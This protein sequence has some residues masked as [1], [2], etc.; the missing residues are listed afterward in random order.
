MSA[1]PAEIETARRIRRRILVRGAVQGVGFRPFV[2][3]RAQALGLSGWV[4]NTAEGVALEIEGGR[5]RV[6]ALLRAL[7]RAPPPNALVTAIAIEALAPCG[8]RGFAIRRSEVA[9]DASAQILPDIAPCAACL[10]ELFDAANRRYRYPFISCSQCGPRYTIIEDGPYDR[11]RTVM[12]Q[13]P[14]CPACQAEYGDP[15]DRRFHAETSACAVCGPRLSLLDGDGAVVARDDT[16]L[17]TAAAALRAGSIVALKG[18]GGFHL[19]A[20]AL[21]DAAVAE[22]RRRKRRPEK[23]FAVMFPSL[24]ALRAGCRLS[25]G[26]AALLTAPARP[27]VLLRRDGAAVAPGVA[28]GNPWLGAMLPSSPLHHL[29]LAALPFPVVATSGN[30]SGEPI[31]IDNAEALARLGGVA[32]RFLV[33]DRPILRP[34]DDSVVRLVARRGLVLRRARGYAPTTLPIRGVRAGVLAVGGHLKTAVA[35]TRENSVILGPHV[36]DLDT[37]AAREAHGRAVGDIARL[38]GVAINRLARDRH[39]DYASARAA[40]ALGLPA[41]AVPHHLAHLVACMAENGIT[42]PVLGVVWDGSGFGEDGTIWGGEFLAVTATG[43]RRI[44]HLRRFRLPGGE[45]AAREPRRA[46]LGMLY[47]AYGG[48]AFAMTDLPPVAAFTARERGVLGTMLVRAVNAPLCSSM[49]RLFDG[50]SALCGLRQRAS[51]EGR[52][53]AE[54]E[55]AADGYAAVRPCAFPVT[56]GAE[57]SP[58]TVDWQPALEA[59]LADLGAGVEPGTVSAALH[60]GLAGAIVDVARRAAIPRV[61]L[62]GGCFQNA[63]LTEAA[64]AAL[65]AAGFE[66]V[67]H[68]RIPP[69]DGGL[70]LGQA[71]WAASHGEQGELPCA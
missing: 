17:E 30:V 38:H 52:A 66:P 57:G 58:L 40:A 2:Y 21:N 55:W 20:D 9:G 29:L 16:A 22:L 45:A 12:R 64:I 71:V 46:A 35:L 65:R 37:V 34:V 67:W 32:D 31:A 50:F 44:A 61:A 25:P 26:E 7:R 70:A 69:N 62:S 49:G 19:I 10:A 4:N 59:A 18:V 6:A 36:G 11:A 51:Y 68:R 41:T 60:A 5:D 56:G 54:L 39:P 53:A 63:R 1:A 15:A 47:E 28:P 43:W 23:P 13:F 3:G 27:I 8:E 14:L 33:H 48:A 24:V 42:P